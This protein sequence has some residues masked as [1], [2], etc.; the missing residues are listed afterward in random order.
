MKSI[1][2][3]DGFRKKYGIFNGT[4]PILRKEKG[5][6]AN[7]EKLIEETGPTLNLVQWSFLDT[8]ELPGGLQ[9]TW[10]SSI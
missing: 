7:G 1:Y 10:W 2:G 9:S 3:V 5:T 4:F 8:R 6:I